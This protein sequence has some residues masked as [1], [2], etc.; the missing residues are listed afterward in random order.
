M[1]TGGLRERKK[2]QTRELISAVATRLFATRGFEATT[3]AEVAAAA[4]VAKMTVTNYFP[5]K[6]DLVFD[7]HEEITG[8]L[9]GAVSARPEGGSAVDAVQAAYLDALAEHRPILGFVGP[10]FA[11][12]VESSPALLAREREIFAAQEHALAEVMM[13]EFATGPGDVRPRVA[14]A[15]LAGIV[16]VLYYEG[17]RLLVAGEP[18]EDIV[19]ALERAAREGF[20][21]VDRAGTV[22]GRRS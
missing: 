18:V 5:L 20:A 15:H 17:R 8:M 11:E 2:Q 13:A 4:E 12:L 9:A 21:A 6:E 7:R 1:S 16:R 19:A 14:A 22:P 3:I 10:R